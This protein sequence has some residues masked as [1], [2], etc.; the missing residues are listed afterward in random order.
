MVVSHNTMILTRFLIRHILAIA[1]MTILGQMGKKKI[2]C[3][4]QFDHSATHLKK[5]KQG[6]AQNV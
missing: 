1:L 2:L 3:G 4:M 6:K 5:K